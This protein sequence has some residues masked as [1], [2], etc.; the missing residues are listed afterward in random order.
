MKTTIILLAALALQTGLASAAETVSA[1]ASDK[2]V[3]RWRATQQS[4]IPVEICLTR[5]QW[6]QRTAQTQQAIREF[7]AR[8]FVKK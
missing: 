2:L 7:Q 1:H 8:S 4:G 3:C 5:R 6:E